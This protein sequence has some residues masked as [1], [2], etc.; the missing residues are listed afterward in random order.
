M[1][2]KTSTERVAY[3]TFSSQREENTRATKE[4]ILRAA[5]KLFSRQGY[6]NTGIGAIAD[7]AGVS[8][9]TFYLHFSTKVAVLNTLIAEFERGILG[10]YKDLAS[11]KHPTFPQLADWVT[12][13]LAYCESDRKSV[14]LVLS[15][16]PKETDL[17]QDWA[18]IY[19]RL[20]TIA[21]KGHQAF[22]L[23]ASGKDA[24]VRGRAITL[25]S[26]IEALPRLVMSPVQICEPQALINAVAESLLRFIDEGAR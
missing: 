14:L 11:I 13:F 4:T 18:D 25:L 10:L 17:A 16:I 15:T 9:Q 2:R 19:Q 3:G 23:A 8:R 21:G 6:A 24:S 22:A 5:Q 26:Q 20:L 1:A 12:R 7:A